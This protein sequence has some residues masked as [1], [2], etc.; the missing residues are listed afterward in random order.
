MPHLDEMNT[1]EI[2]I[3]VIISA[4]IEWRSVRQLVSE[5]KIES[6]PYGEFFRLTKN[7]E[8][9]D[10]D[11]IFVHGGWGKISA[12][13]S[14]QYVFDRWNPR[15]L[16]NLGT[17]GGFEGEIDGGG[18]ILVDQTIVYDIFEQMGDSE[19][20]I[21]FYSTRIDLSWLK[22]PYPDEVHQG[23]LISADRDLRP[24]DI[25]EL[26]R[27]YGA[28]AGDW[29]SGAIAFV[30]KRNGVPCLILRGV[31]D[32]VNETGGEAYEDINVFAIS[33]KEIMSRLLNSLPAWIEKADVF[34]D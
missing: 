7:I 28:F 9:R 6:S 31:S 10:R 30:A 34:M 27:K 12:A 23:L 13:A 18:I 17:C 26:K 20:D 16:I 29:E 24:E 14:A 4:D 8:N 1:A 3:V 19:A 32:L 21:A 11:L 33:A 5:V 22:K 15:L 2:D 25:G